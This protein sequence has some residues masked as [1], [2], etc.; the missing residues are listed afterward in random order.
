MDISTLKII[1]DIT[2]TPQGMNINWAEAGKAAAAAATTFGPTLI[3]KAIQNRNAYPQ[4]GSRPIFPG[5]RRQAYEQ[6]VSNALQLQTQ[7]RAASTTN[8]D[9]LK[10]ATPF[11]LI[12]GL[13]AG[14]YF[15]NKSK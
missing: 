12:G 10:N 11:L 3:N 1:N 8:Q 5:R 2:K 15:Y 6:C 13:V 9:I 14:I 4:C 7:Q